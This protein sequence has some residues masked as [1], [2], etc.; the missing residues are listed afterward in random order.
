MD[1]IEE[2]CEDTAREVEINLDTRYSFPGQISIQ[3]YAESYL[4]IF[5]EGI[6]WLVLEND[7]QLDA[8]R[9]LQGG[10][11]VGETL[12]AFDE[13]DVANVI[14]QIE[15]KQFYNP[16]VG[17]RLEKNM[18]ALL[19]NRCNQ[20]CR[21]C[22]MYAGDVDYEEMSADQWISVLDNFKMC[23]GAGVTF[24]GGE[25]TV[26][27]GFDRIIKHAHNIGLSVTVLTNGMLW[28]QDAVDDLHFAIDEIQVSV[29]G[30]DAPSYYSVRQYDGF[31]KALDCIRRFSK[32]DTKVSMAV[33]PLQSDLDACVEGFEHFARGFL[34]EYP[35]V[36]IK[37]NL[38]LLQGREVSATPEE[39]KEYRRKLR[40]LVEVLYPNYYTETFVLNY[41]DRS[42]R[43]NC[44]FGEITIAANGDVYWCNRIPELSPAANVLK[45]DFTEIMLISE[46][47]KEDTAVDNTAGCK[48]CD[49]RYICGGGCRLEYAGIKEAAS[50]V[51]EWQFSCR[52]K[53]EIYKKMI[54]SNEYFFM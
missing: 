24:T 51:G 54:L 8:F 15:A 7:S 37:L 9:M 32:T 14:M 41:E 39:N 11:T 3:K 36:F 52:G 40:H 6:A 47:V 30:F 45:D 49:I 5:T 2:S 27:D 44:G 26:Y 21:H 18:Y 22:F 20:R 13:S 43:Q 29:D 17:A 38:E 46:R 50:H 12:D 4:A 42:I 53:G 48:D 31:D 23:G 28:T 34:A 25:V 35:D 10:R 33:T 1:T 16:P 19:T